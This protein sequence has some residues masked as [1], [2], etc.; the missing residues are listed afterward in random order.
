MNDIIEIMMQFGYSRQEAKRITEMQNPG[1][2][3][4]EKINRKLQRMVRKG[5]TA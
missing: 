4:L 5:V 3:K 1:L 2:A